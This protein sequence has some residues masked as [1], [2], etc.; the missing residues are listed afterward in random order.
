M[1]VPRG[2]GH[3]CFGIAPGR[4]DA[5]WVVWVSVFGEDLDVL[6]GWTTMDQAQAAL[7]R[8][9]AALEKGQRRLFE[10]IER[11]RAAEG[12]VAPHQLAPERMD[13]LRPIIARK[14][15]LS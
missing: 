7:R 10:E 5:A 2:R 9:I 13:Q 1:L 4:D 12:Y 11:A 6:S 3:V 14:V 15:G 8:Y